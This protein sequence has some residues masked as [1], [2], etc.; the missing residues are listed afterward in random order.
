MNDQVVYLIHIEPRYRHAGHYVGYTRTD[1]YARFDDHRR[2]RGAVARLW[3]GVPRKFELAL[4]KTS[5]VELCPICCG[6]E[7]ALRRFAR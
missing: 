4:K 2:G 6:A 3:W 1:V 5:Q 7:K